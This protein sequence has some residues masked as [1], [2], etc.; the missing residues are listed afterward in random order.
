V[1]DGWLH[2]RRPV[3]PDEE[4][5]LKEVLEDTHDAFKAAVRESRSPKLDTGQTEPIHLL[6]TDVSTAI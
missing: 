1:S 3:R 4:V 6:N 5:K 2:A